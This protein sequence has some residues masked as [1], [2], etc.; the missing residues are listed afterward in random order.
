MLQA[1]ALNAVLWAC[2]RRNQ[3]DIYSGAYFVAKK[4]ATKQSPP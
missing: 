2:N 1:F 3:A 4:P